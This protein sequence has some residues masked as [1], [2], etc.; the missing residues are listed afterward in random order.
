MLSLAAYCGYCFALNTNQCAYSPVDIFATS[1][2][3]ELGTNAVPKSLPQDS[4]ACFASSFQ[5]QEERGTSYVLPGL[6]ASARPSESSLATASNVSDDTRITITPNW[7]AT[8]LN[9]SQPVIN[10]DPEEINHAQTIDKKELSIESSQQPGK[11]FLSFGEWKRIRFGKIEDVRSK[12]KSSQPIRG[13]G[14]QQQMIDSIDGVFSDDFGSMFEGFA[15]KA[16]HNVY[17]EGEYIAP[18][19]PSHWEPAKEAKAKKNTNAPIKTLNERSNYASTDCA[20]TVRAANI[21]AK[22]ANTILYESKDQYML[23]KCS[24][25]KYVIIKLCEEIMIDTIVLA[26][27]EFFSSTFKDFR[28]YVADRYPTVEWKFLGQWQAK[29]TR[30]LQVFKVED[31]FGWPQYMKIEFLTHYGQEYYCPLSL[32]RVHGLP[33]FELYNLYESDTLS[34]EGEQTNLM[35]EDILWP[36]E[37]RQE[38]I[39]PTSD[40]SKLPEPLFDDENRQKEEAVQIPR[41]IAVVQDEIITSSRTSNIQTATVDDWASKQPSVSDTSIQRSEQ[42]MIASIA[43]PYPSVPDTKRSDNEPDPST[44]TLKYE[45]RQETSMTLHAEVSR[46][47]QISSSVSTPSVFATT[48]DTA[49]STG[50]SK[51]NN[52]ISEEERANSPKPIPNVH[53]KEANTQESIYKTIMKRLNALELNMTLSQRYM[54]EQNKMLNDVFMDMETRHQEQLLLLIG[55]LNET[56]STRIENMERNGGEDEYLGRTGEAK[57]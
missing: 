51:E 35:E 32:V 6:Y 17:A 13:N 55:H 11:L 37:I 41:P 8:V 1:R 52:S 39:K 43:L 16:E 31:R 9:V 56:A 53:S 50:Q 18:S 7:N 54:D 30:D 47:A 40:M 42:T 15:D 29:N 14:R 5:C 27:F 36:S 34:G 22:R 24:A 23:N 44:V 19:R 48:T 2:T 46:S 21:G 12:R 20:A 3:V 38:I 4:P 45:S 49:F 25:D 26:N 57:D 10:V 28:V 33:M